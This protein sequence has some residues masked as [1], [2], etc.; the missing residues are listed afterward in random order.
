M[1]N[2]TNLP[3]AFALLLFATLALPIGNAVAQDAKSIAGTYS[4]VSNSPFG[5]NARGQMILGPDGH[6]SIIIARATLTKF[7]A[8]ARDKG[9]AEENKAIVGG[10]IAHY[11]TYTVDQKDKTITFNVEASTY[12]NWDGNTFRRPLKVVG[13]LLTYTNNAPSGGGGAI[14]V[15]W[16]RVK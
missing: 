13:D 8:G 1:K 5:D 7:A 15:V 11:G 4:S 14:D 6:Y 3:A 10:S 2:R 9:T 12:P 16:K